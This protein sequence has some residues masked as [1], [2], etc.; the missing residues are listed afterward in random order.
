MRKHQKKPMTEREQKK[1]LTELDKL[2]G[3]DRSAKLELLNQSILHCWL[4]VYPLKETL[5][6]FEATAPVF[7]KYAPR[8]G[9]PRE[10]QNPAAKRTPSLCCLVCT[11]ATRR[12]GI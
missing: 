7:I 5:E 2:S 6:R 1:L 11:C 4:S 3:G 10:K 8:T 9:F 12:K